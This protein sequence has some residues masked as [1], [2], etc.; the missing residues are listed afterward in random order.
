MKITEIISE[1][2]TDEFVG[3]AVKGLSGLFKGAKTGSQS[4]QALPKATSAGSA[5]R[6]MGLDPKGWLGSFYRR[7]M[8]NQTKQARAVYRTRAV[9]MAR[10]QLGDDI[11]KWVTRLAIVDGIYDYYTAKSVL[12][13][14]L[15]QGQITREEYDQELTDI[16]GKFWAA[17]LVPKFAGTISKG[18]VGGVSGLLTKLGA[19]KSGEAVRFWAGSLAKGGEAAGLAIL[20]TDEGKKWLADSLGF[21]V[22]G[23]GMAADL[24]S[25]FLVF[26]KSAAQVATG[27]VPDDVKA[28]AGIG[29][30]SKDQDTAGDN[31]MGIPVKKGQF[32]DP[33]KGTSRSDT[34]L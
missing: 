11:L 32:Q 4:M 19:P 22:T 3:A 29:D 20:S 25:K 8:I 28:A 30:K 33:F 6:S 23:F 16:R 15:A 9:N 27:T 31:I 14:L 24:V 7:R 13:D 1:E 34:V 2:R 21:V 18:V 12:D 10:D 17:I 5:V 26:L